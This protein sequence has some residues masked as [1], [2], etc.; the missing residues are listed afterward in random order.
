M[1]PNNPQIEQD[2][3]RFSALAAPSRLKALP[4]D[5]GKKKKYNVSHTRNRSI[6]FLS[7][8]PVF[9][10]RKVAKLNRNISNNRN[11]IIDRIIIDF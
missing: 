5:F 3:R 9:S 1:C 11:K 4:I 7:V 2:D 8:S 6:P 10:E